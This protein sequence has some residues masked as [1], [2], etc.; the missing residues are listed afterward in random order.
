[1]QH[2]YPVSWLS[3]CEYSEEVAIQSEEISAGIWQCFL[4]RY[5][6]CEQRLIPDGRGIVVHSLTKT[7]SEKQ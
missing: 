1:M 4:C 5:G 2:V 6:L 7:L 3:E